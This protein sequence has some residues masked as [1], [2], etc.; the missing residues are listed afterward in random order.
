MEKIRI[1]DLGT[2]TLGITKR[3]GLIRAPEVQEDALIE[4]VEEP[5]EPGRPHHLH[6]PV[7]RIRIRDPGWVKI[8][9]PDPG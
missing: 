6:Q 1:R 7:L 8:R 5:G 3:K 4:L 9:S 2:A